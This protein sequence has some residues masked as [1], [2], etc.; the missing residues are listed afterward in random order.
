MN[1]YSDETYGE[2]VAS[3]YDD[4]FSEYDPHAIDVLASLAQKHISIFSF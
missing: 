4:W 3:V 1:F 2:S